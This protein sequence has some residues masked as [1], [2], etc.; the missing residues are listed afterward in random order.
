MELDP[1]DAV[2]VHGDGGDVAGE[3]RVA[4]VGRDADGFAGIGAA[5]IEDV[6]PALTVDDVAAVARVP[7]ES[8]VAVAEGRHIVALAADD[9]V[10]AVA[11]KDHVVSGTAVDRQIDLV[12][13][14]TAGIDLIVAG[15]GQYP[16]L[17]E[18]G[19]GMLDRDR[20]AQPAH[21]HRTA[22]ATDRD[23]IAAGRCGND[24][25]I[26]L[27]VAGAPARG[28]QVDRNL[29]YVGSVE[30]ADGDGVGA[31]R[32]CELDALDAVEVH[33]DGADVAEKPRPI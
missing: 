16:E 32:S 7:D 4:A 9:G 14:K 11:S 17:I 15:A 18:P 2:E 3:Q 23:V 29:R 30:V 10:I 12:G 27:A 20:L 21:R 13:W 25:L 22:V 8:I 6:E 24:D 28:R 31:P 1:L 5:E 19:I 33:A 26:E